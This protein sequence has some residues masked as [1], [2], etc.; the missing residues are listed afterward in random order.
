[1]RMNAEKNSDDITEEAGWREASC[2]VVSIIEKD[3]NKLQRRYIGSLP[4]KGKQTL[5]AQLR[6]KVSHILG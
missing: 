2:G 5:K 4:E 1:M 6:Q 3:Y